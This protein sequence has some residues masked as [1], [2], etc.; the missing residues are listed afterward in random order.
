M[1]RFHKFAGISEWDRTNG[2]SRERWLRIEL[3]SNMVWRN[4]MQNLKKPALFFQAIVLALVLGLCFI[5]ASAEDSHITLDNASAAVTGSARSETSGY[6]NNLN[7]GSKVTYTAGNNVSGNFDVYLEVSRAAIGLG[8]TPF[9]ISV[10]GGQETVPIIEYGFSKTDKS[11]LYDKGVFLCRNNAALKAGDKITITGLPGFALGASSF[12]PGIGDIRLYQPGAK[13]AVGYNGV[14]PSEQSTNTADS[15]S[16]L[17]LIWLGSSVTYGQQAQGYSMADYLEESHPALKSYKYTVSGTTLV[18]D[19]ST[20]YVSRMKQ[21]PTDIRPDFFIIQLSTNDAALRKPF[22]ALSSS[23]DLSGF[24][25]HTIYGAMEYVI[26]YA[27]TTWHCPV[28]F[29]TGTYYDAKTYNNDGAAYGKTV[30]ALLDVQKKWG[31]NVIDLYDDASMSAIYNTDQ[32]KKYMSD[33]VHPTAN[34]Y[35]TWWG[36]KFEQALTSYVTS[37]P[38]R[39]SERPYP[40][41]K[42]GDGALKLEERNIPTTVNLATIYARKTR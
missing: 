4:N 39:P 29:F 12:L 22:G 16:G 42:P 18:D 21:I 34:G 6:I 28:V 25:T 15:L 14:I 13:V 5:T 32:Y 36:L 26:A 24:D 38:P 33:G 2:L 10:N 40:S 41:S 3:T 19:S 23:T 9:S 27:S 37:R 31:I 17:Q 35:K 7:P 1:G 11:D 20:S 8:T 30:K